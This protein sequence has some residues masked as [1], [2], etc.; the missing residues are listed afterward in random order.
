[1]RSLSENLEEAYSLG[2]T[3]AGAKW[4]R[5]W[6]NKLF[7]TL[8]V[9]FSKFE[10]DYQFNLQSTL[11]DR[12]EIRDRSF[13]LTRDNFLEERTVRFD[14]E[15]QLNTNNQLEFGLFLVDNSI[16]YD[17]KIIETQ[18]ER[19]LENNATQVGFYMLMM[20]RIFKKFGK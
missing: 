12:E 11:T 10:K 2:N 5:Y 6:N 8:S 4:S 7:T 18:K 17:D 13:I 20:E 19:S 16:S 15:Y 3:G 14:T 9:G 1:V